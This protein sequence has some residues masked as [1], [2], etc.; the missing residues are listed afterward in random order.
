MLKQQAASISAEQILYGYRDGH[1]RLAGSMTLDKAAESTILVLSDL[2]GA[3]LARGF[4]EYITAYPIPESSYYAVAKTWYAPEMPRPGCVWTHALLI[5]RQDLGNLSS[6]EA[7][8]SAF[9]RPA[10]DAGFDSYEASISLVSPRHQ[11]TSEGNWAIAQGAALLNAVYGG[12]SSGTLLLSETARHYEQLVLRLW[13]QQWPSLRQNF[14]FC[15]GAIENRDMPE[16]TF[17]LQ[18]VPLRAARNLEREGRQVLDLGHESIDLPN[19]NWLSM[20]AEDLHCDEPTAF[21]RFLWAFADPL[22]SRRF[23]PLLADIYGEVAVVPSEWKAKT[24]VETICATFP[25]P[26]IEPELKSAMFSEVYTPA[27]KLFWRE[28]QI[29][30]CLLKGAGH[31]CFEWSTLSIE[32]RAAKLWENAPTIARQLAL[33]VAGSPLTEAGGQFLKGLALG[34]AEEELVVRFGT[35]IGLFAAVL[36]EV[37]HLL[38]RPQLWEAVLTADPQTVGV[39]GDFSP[40]L[41]SFDEIDSSLWLRLARAS[42]SNFRAPTRKCTLIF[43]FGRAIRVRTRAGAQIAAIVFDDVYDIAGR[44]LTNATEGCIDRALP[45]PRR[46]R[47]IRHSLR[48]AVLDQ[49]FKGAWP[50][51]SM[52]SLTQ[53]PTT[54]KKLIQDA[55]LSERGRRFVHNLL[56]ESRQGN[57]KAADWQSAIL[58]KYDR[59]SMFPFLEGLSIFPEDEPD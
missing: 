49:F 6:T 41:E 10:S 43:M 14:A 53:R 34:V 25:S 46:N 52:L 28:D 21:R 48:R 50:A 17:D 22:S 7:L 26:G 51:A 38:G 58:Y 44:S 37:P 35:D 13:L 4:E 30:K 23:L 2:S 11:D 16:L 8:L 59:R 19:D 54:F 33:E 40:A 20:A 47:S 5:N 56:E 31:T 18:V 1:G 15:T 55:R 45:Q 12:G 27:Q 24:A 3:S 29:L 32:T 57:L 42:T 9:R 39:L 36:H